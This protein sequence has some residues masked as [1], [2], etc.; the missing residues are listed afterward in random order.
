MLMDYTFMD[1][2]TDLMAMF[3]AISFILANFFFIVYMRNLK[4][5]RWFVASILISFVAILLMFFTV[6]FFHAY[7][8]CKSYYSCQG[9]CPQLYSESHLCFQPIDI[10][11]P[12]LVAI[13]VIIVLIGLVKTKQARHKIWPYFVALLLS[14]LITVPIY[15]GIT[16]VFT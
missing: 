4:T 7:D 15:Y 16:A 5:Y 14:F 1:I 12:L 9:I 11:C 6:P 2:P 13:S 3:F 10:V 8:N